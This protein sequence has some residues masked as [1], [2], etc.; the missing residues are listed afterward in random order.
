MSMES[1][2]EDLGL[3]PGI[4]TIQNL[5]TMPDVSVRFL[6]PEI[7]R[8][9][10]RLGMRRNAIWPNLVAVEQSVSQPT[11][12]QPWMNMS[13]ATPEYVGEAETIPVGYISYGQKQVSIRKMGK[14][15]KVSYELKNYVAINLVALFM[16]DVGIRMGQGLDTLAISTL[17]NGDQ[18]NGSESAPVV[19]VATTGTTAYRDIL[20]VWI[21][22]SRLGRKADTIIGGEAAALDTLDLDEFKERSAGTTQANLTLKTPVPTSSNYFIHGSV[23]DDQQIIVDSNSALIKYNAQP[24][25][26]ET[27]K[28]VSNQTELT[29][30]TTTTGFANIWRD[31]RVIL[32][33]SL[34]VTTNDFPSYMDMEAQEA[35]IVIE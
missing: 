12:H 13:D 32:D 2:Y 31:A 35:N 10:L 33:Q 15:I 27:E 29:V 4:D 26:M 34:D 24:L 6:V 14:G 3:D 30:V 21:R 19:G 22:M 8:D 7:Y 5:I 25:L 18:A 9:A 28:I 16:Q 23:P 20:R 17:I 1:F 11:I